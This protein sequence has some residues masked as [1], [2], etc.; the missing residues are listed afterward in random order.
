M[1]GYD[2]YFGSMVF[3]VAPETINMKINGRNT[4]YDLINEGELNVLKLA[5]LTTVN[6]T[7]LLPA[8][9]YP[10]ATYPDGF[11]VPGY[12]LN[13]LER[14]KQSRQP[15]QFIISRHGNKGIWTNLYNTNMTASIEDYTIKEDARNNGFDTSVEITLK[16]FKDFK[17]EVFNV[18]TPAPTAP[19][20]L[21]PARS[22]STASTGTNRDGGSSGGGSGG[23]GKKKKYK[24]QIPGMGAVEVWATSVQDAITKAGAGSWTGTIYVDDSTYYVS[25]G[26]LG[27]DPATIRKAT[28]GALKTMVNVSAAINTVVTAASIT[29]AVTGLQKLQS[30]VT[31]TVNNILT[32]D[33]R[34][35]N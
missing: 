17:T 3:P 33:V 16:Q 10:F 22:D 11:K 24:V 4:T 32:R 34:K 20:A 25:T 14:L 6:F 18:V 21:E 15:F 5:G 30:A 29:G 13:E 31:K 12:Y 7:V 8:T 9:R 23:G 26:T 19:I 2:L 1:A 35:K 27:V 28:S